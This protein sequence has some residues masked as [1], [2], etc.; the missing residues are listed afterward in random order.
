MI[1][2]KTFLKIL[3]KN[4][5]IVALYTVILVAFG[6]FNMK[7]SDNNM[8]FQ[9][10]QPSIYIINQDDHFITEN[11]IQYMSKQCKIVKL[12]YDKNA[13]ADALFYREVSYIIRIPQGYGDDF[14]NGKN[15]QIV[16]E[17]T[18]DYE[19]SYADM[20]LSRYLNVANLY[21]QIYDDGKVIIHKI[22]ETLAL[23]TDIKMATQVD[24]TQLSQATFYYN[25]MNYSL[26]AGCVYIICLILSSFREEAIS[27]RIAISSMNTKKHQL[28]LLAS[29]SL[30]AL[31]LWLIYVLLSFILVGQVMFTVHG[32]FYIF[33]S[34]IFTIC[35]LT[36][37]FLIAHLVSNKNIINGIVNVVALGSSFLC[38]AFV[39]IEYLPDIVLKIAHILPS[40][41]YIQG[42]EWIE[43]VETFHLI[44][45]KPFFVN[46]GIVLVFALVFIVMSHVVVKRN[47]G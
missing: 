7:T 43:T 29:N 25:F 47:N 22:N 8:N 21:Q 23:Q 4:I 38:G 26:L 24:T 19:S 20:L 31:F 13:I 11:L 15:P 28:I 6:G 18:G 2:F 41:W 17:S 33:N 35:S 3:K 30:L 46:I 45:L 10:S 32:L 40:Y 14:L 16:I 34:F 9:D 27:K 36:L 37:A 5:G 42:N 39:P 1:V 12:S 44:S